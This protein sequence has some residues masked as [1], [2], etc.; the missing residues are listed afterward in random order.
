MRFLKTFAVLL[1]L[2]AVGIGLIIG[3]MELCVL[4]VG[5]DWFLLPWGIGL[6]AAT[7]AIITAM[8]A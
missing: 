3:W 8:D 2:T 7:A 6:L 4:L 5:D 1:A